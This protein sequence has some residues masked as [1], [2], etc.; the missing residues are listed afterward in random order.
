MISGG[1]PFT[2]VSRYCDGKSYLEPFFQKVVSLGVIQENSL[3]ISVWSRFRLCYLK[4]CLLIV[5]DCKEIAKS[6]SVFL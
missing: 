4:L 2:V 6:G 5:M 3:C 1:N